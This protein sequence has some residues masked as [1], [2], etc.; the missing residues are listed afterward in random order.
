MLVAP[1]TQLEHVEASEVIVA[2]GGRYVEWEEAAQPERHR[3]VDAEQD[4]C[5]QRTRDRQI[6]AVMNGDQEQGCQENLL[7]DRWWHR[8]QQ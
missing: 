5:C 4:C 6:G 3:K 1:K 7:L 8:L 2:I